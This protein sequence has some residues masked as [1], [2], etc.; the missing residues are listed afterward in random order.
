VTVAEKVRKFIRAERE[1]SSFTGETI[2]RSDKAKSNVSGFVS[3]K[4]TR[5]SDFAI[6]RASGKAF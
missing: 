4:Y 5:C 1:R 6:A 2:V 3:R